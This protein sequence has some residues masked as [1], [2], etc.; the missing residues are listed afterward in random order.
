LLEFKKKFKN[1]KENTMKTERKKG[2][3]NK[4][5]EQTREERIKNQK[6]KPNNMGRGSLFSGV[7]ELGYKWTLAAGR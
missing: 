1:R 4:K 5:A 6:G 2:K 7:L 3:T